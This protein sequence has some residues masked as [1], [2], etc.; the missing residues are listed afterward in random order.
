MWNIGPANDRRR[1]VVDDLP[2][3]TDQRGHSTTRPWRRRAAPA[4][5]SGV[6]AASGFPSWDRSP[7]RSWQ[8]QPA[9]IWSSGQ[10]RVSGRSWH[11]PRSTCSCQSAHALQVAPQVAPKPLRLWNAPSSSPGTRSSFRPRTRCRRAWQRSA[12]SHAW[13]RLLTPTPERPCHSLSPPGR[14]LPS[15]G[16][17]PPPGRAGRV[18][19]QMACRPAERLRNRRASARWEL[20]RRTAVPRLCALAYQ[21]SSGAWHPTRKL[22]DP[23]APRVAVHHRATRSRKDRSRTLVQPEPIRTTAPRAANAAHSTARK[24]SNAPWQSPTCTTAST[25]S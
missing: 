16:G 23:R 21:C 3:P 5:M 14:P 25:P 15:A 18:R 20:P 19:V 8:G 12:L 13:W 10:H 17:S 4:L 9:A 2:T 7:A 6:N 22:D 1:T 11:R 24:Y